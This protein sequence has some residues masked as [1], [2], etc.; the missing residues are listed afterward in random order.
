MTAQ[1]LKPQLPKQSKSTLYDIDEIQELEIKVQVYLEKENLKYF[2][3]E[4]YVFSMMKDP[5]REVTHLPMLIGH[6]KPKTRQENEIIKQSLTQLLEDKKRE[7]DIL[8]KK[9]NKNIRLT[10]AGYLPFPKGVGA[11]KYLQVVIDNAAAS[12]TELLH[13]LSLR[14]RRV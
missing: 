11:I 10:T 13:Y 7:I 5:D 1:V 9:G 8:R 14:T 3:A 2:D 4:N 12:D 6:I